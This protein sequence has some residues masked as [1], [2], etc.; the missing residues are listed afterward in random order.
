MKT[1]NELTIE[2]ARVGLDNKEFTSVEL[3]QACLDRIHDRNEEINAF[4]TVTDDLALVEAKKADA[5]IVKG[6][7]KMLTG[8]PYSVK[9]AICTL[10]VRST[11]S[12][13]ILDNYI[14]PFDATVIKKIREQGAVLVG[15]TNCDAFGHGASNEQSM[16][17]PVKNPHDTRK[18]A[19]GS[20]GGAAASV[21]DHQCLF[22][23]AE[24]TGGSIRQPAAFCGVYG[25]RPSYGRNSRYGIMPM[26]SSFDTVGPMAKTAADIAILMEVM[27][28]VD[29]KDATTVPDAVPAYKKEIEKLEIRNLRV[30]VPKEYFELEGLTDEVKEAIE[31]KIEELKKQGATIVPVSLPHTKYAIPVYYI[32]VPSEDSSN[33]GRID[34]IRYG[35][36]SDMEKLY[37]TYAH[38]REHGFPEEVK[39]RIM[40]GT[41]ALS[42]GY[43]DA[44]YRKAQQ[45][46]TLIMQ[47]FDTVFQ[48][49][50][51]L[52]TPT[53]PFP[54]FGIG[55]KKDDVIAM[56]LADVF[57]SPASVAGIP[58][59]S[60]PAGMSKN[61]LPIG[62]QI[63]GPRLGES[64]ILQVA[65]VL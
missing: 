16:Y 46:R 41:Y 12:A 63:L 1:L 58:G 6:E 2:Q 4:I 64:K 39:R 17:G 54:A 43:Y 45:V 19:G 34:G 9:D 40:L 56:Y 13:K 31:S 15:K 26:A 48:D 59:I 27:A 8:I 30:G 44:Y 29:A 37:D 57:V 23:I 25:I 61:G 52:I 5:M 21:A 7:Q 24:D 22:A 55:E 32:A 35:V 62:M 60:V 38:S 36:Q 53:S 11:A 14:P 47:D 28:G 3:T 50:D 42:A 20:S 18:V 33:L 51:V 10:D 65:N 49:V